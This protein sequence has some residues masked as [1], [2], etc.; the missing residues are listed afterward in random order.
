MISLYDL[1]HKYNKVF[2]EYSNHLRT[3]VDSGDYILGDELKEFETKVSSVTRHHYAHGVANGT[4]ALLLAL[5]FLLKNVNKSIENP[6]VITSPLSYLATTSTILLSG[7]KPV[8]ACL[9]HSLNISPA[10]IEAKITNNTV[11]IQLVHYSGNPADTTAI[12]QIA[13]KYNLFL[14]EDCAQ[15]FGAR[16]NSEHVGATADAS[17]LSFHP[18]KLLSVMGDGGMVLHNSQDM[19]D[20][21]LQARNHGHI[22]RDD[23]AFPSINSRLD[24]IHAV[25]GSLYLIHALNEIEVRRA[26][27]KIVREHLD[28]PLIKLPK[29]HSGA[30]PSYNWL[31][32]RVR[33]RP[34]FL[35]FLASKSI[36]AKVH[37]PLLIPEMQ[38]IRK[39]TNVSLD[40][41][42]DR[43]TRAISR[44]IVSVPIG[45]HLTDNHLGCLVD[46]LNSY[47]VS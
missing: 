21:L 10:D 33:D 2:N 44:E 29:I 43:L 46:T 38:F 39:F 36:E 1:P 20:W 15:A 18:L 3:I 26:Q 16:I 47:K 32:L 40:C 41:L 25:F 13:D 14:I 8:F 34:K 31:V 9:D 4:D 7:C 19:S 17:T 22:S 37:Y 5:R 35:E 24:N 23:A 12:R 42:E 27:A 11:G 6:E 28:N 45:T 30:E